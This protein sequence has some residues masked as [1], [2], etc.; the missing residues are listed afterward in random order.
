MQEHV[1]T[2][3]RLIIQSPKLLSMFVDEITTMDCQ[4]W[5]FVHV[6]ETHAYFAN[7]GTSVV[8]CYCR[9]PNYCDYGK[10]VI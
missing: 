4:R 10:L 8:W 5:I 6:L 2:K 1:L 9:Q 3:T 7:I